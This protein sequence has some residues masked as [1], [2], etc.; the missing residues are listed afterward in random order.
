MGYNQYVIVTG[1][2]LGSGKS[3]SALWLCWMFDKKFS[4]EKSLAYNLQQ[5]ARI[6]RQRQRDVWVTF[7]EAQESIASTNWMDLDDSVKKFIVTQRENHINLV[8]ATPNVTRLAYFIRDNY[9]WNL[10]I[11]HRCK[12]HCAG[13]IYS[14]SGN[15]HVDG[16]FTVYGTFTIPKPTDPYF[17]AEVKKYHDQFK[18]A[19][20]GESQQEFMV[21]ALEGGQTKKLAERFYPWFLQQEHRNK[22]GEMMRPELI[23]VKVWLDGLRAQGEDISLNDAE[24]QKV[25]AYARNIWYSQT[26]PDLKAKGEVNNE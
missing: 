1:S 4:I 8:I 21:D 5:L 7:D 19:Y 24:Q 12:S 23:Q 26:L 9:N 11:I 10:H 25:Y 3:E 13:Y 16:E 20:M 14:R 18:A 6:I 2:R 22:K 15:P 17:V